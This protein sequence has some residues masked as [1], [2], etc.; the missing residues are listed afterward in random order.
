[1]PDEIR[2]QVRSFFL[3]YAHSPPLPGTPHVAPDQ[4]VRTFF[5]DLTN[6]VRQLGSARAGV[7]PGFFDQEIP[8]GSDRRASL[9]HALST[10]EVFVPLYS[11]GYFARSRPGREWACFE[12][13]LTDAGV[14]NPIDRIAPVLWIPL[15]PG[16]DP[17]GLDQALAIGAGESAYAENGLR[18]LLRLAP[19][20]ESY[21]RI[22][23]Q[24]AGQIVELAENAPVGPSAVRDIDKVASPFGQSATA[25]FTITVAAPTQSGLPVGC[26]PAAYGASRSAWRPF[27][28]VQE[29]SLAEYVAT[30][31]EQLDFA[32]ALADIDQAGSELAANPGVILIDPWFA[33][34]EI[35]LDALRR[36][37]YERPWILP[38]LVPT[39][40]DDSGHEAML[41]QRIRAAL[42]E[43]QPARTE[44]ARQAVAG[45][46]SFERF[47][48]LVPYV[49]AEASRQYLRHGPGNRQTELPGPQLQI[50]G[51][52]LTSPATHE[53]NPDDPAPVQT[54]PQSRGG[55][56]VTFYSF[57]GG[58]G[59]TMAL[60]N[61]AWILAANG[62][63]VLV[64]DWD[65]EA[66]G[67]DRF[68]LPF[69][70]EQEV[71]DGPGIIDLIRDY[72]R[73]AL[74]TDPANREGLISEFSRVQRYAFSLNWEFPDYGCL[75]FLSA[76]KQNRDYVATLSALDWDS[77]YESLNGGEFL[78]ALRADMKR[79]YD[80]VLI[81]SR[82][83]LSDIAD[84]CTLHLPD[85]LVDCF[86][87][88]TQG[89]EGAA[90]IA[91]DIK[92][93]HSD[94]GIRVLP[95]TM[96]VDQAEKE[97]VDAGRLVAMRQFSGLPEGMTDVQRREYWAA[98]EIP[99]QA[100]YAYEETLAVFG[101]EPGKP[102]SLLASFERLTAQITED[103]VTSLPPMDEQLR[104]RN[105]VKFTRSVPLV[106]DLIVIQSLAE[107]ALWTEW[108][109]AVSR[110]AGI[111][112][113]QQRLDGEDAEPTATGSDRLRFPRTLTVVSAAYLARRKRLSLPQDR[114]DLAVYVT[115]SP[116]LSEFSSVPAAFL[117]G[118][119][120]SEAIDR[121]RTLLGLIGRSAASSAAVGMRYPGSEP[122]IFEVPA[123][124]AW[125]TGREADLGR[126][127]A[128]LLEYG[129]GGV[130]SVAL[131]GLGGIG[132]TQLALEYAHRFKTN[133]DAIW[134]L[135]CGQPAFIEPSLADLAQRLRESWGLNVVPSAN[136]TETARQVLDLLSRGGPRW[137]LVFDDADQIEA[138]LPLLPSGGGHVLVTSTNR[139]W[140]E[141]G[142]S[143]LQVDVFTREESVAHLRQ[144]V[145]SMTTDEAEQ[146]AAALGDLP[147]AVATAG[148]WVAETGYTV[149]DFLAEL[150]RQ[151]RRALSVATLPD[152]PE[153]ISKA[154]DVS[155]SR[156][157][158]RSPAA[159]RLFELC[160]IMAPTISLNLIYSPRMAAVLEPF[161]PALSETM[162]IARVVQ[163]IYRLALIKLEPGAGQLIVHTL[164]QEV[165]RDR[166]S[167]E[168]LAAARCDVH[169][170]LVAARPRRDVDDPAT[171]SRYRVIW[172][173]LTVSQAMASAEEGVRHLY[174]D[175]V[176]Y[177]W[178]RG[179]LERGRQLAVEV[180]ACWT[181]MEK[182]AA[183]TPVVAETLRKQLLQL[184]FNL[185]NI[186][187]D[188]GCFAEARELNATIWDEQMRL[189]GDDHPHTLMTAGALAA[190]LRAGGRYREALEMDEKTHQAW[191]ELFGGDHPRTL[192]AA[193][194]LGVSLR[195]TGDFA[196][197]MR[198][199]ADTWERRRATLGPKDPWT[200]NSACSIARDLLEAGEYAEAAVQIEEVCRTFAEVL[201]A[202]S[203][204][205]L[206]SQVLLGIALRSTGRPDEAEELFR[207]ALGELTKKFG[208]SSGGAL[209]CRLSYAVNS[210]S[211]DR[212]AGAA[213]DIRQIFAA[214][215]Q[216]LGSEHPHTLACQVNLAIALRFAGEHQEAVQA[217]RQS[218]D[219]LAAVLGDEHPYALAAKM[220][221]GV[222]LADA[223]DLQE[224]EKAEA[225]AADG[226]AR[227]L[228]PGHPDTLRCRAN[229]LLTR[230]QR[231]DHAAVAQRSTVVDQLAV[232]LGGD[233]PT[234]T[235]HAAKT[236]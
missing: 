234:V 60:A 28:A 13:R 142:V 39:P 160:S 105:M 41:V 206:E 143:P 73:A 210:L 137:L 48:A 145:P 211:L 88:S 208:G 27:P 11:P 18:A 35:G 214:Y 104:K 152:H 171:W 33:A 140:A 156:L 12:R 228:G 68:F 2:P 225:N 136:P 147:L 82:T 106:G 173:H 101:D 168:E 36:A 181:A 84:I 6:S 115:P 166:M 108:I 16:H 182:T 65:L 165:V 123:R 47:V 51:G 80:Y 126:L 78:D 174:I 107:D 200:L 113:R 79:N 49:I 170:V 111:D 204:E 1:V 96:R 150:E 55:R 119:P 167:P 190:D 24:L 45:V 75:D 52:E 59:R 195:V 95:V 66:P 163:E 221:A 69:L 235:T 233:H 201:G 146:I 21:W 61:V 212:F 43:S 151:P 22:V 203:K 98:I 37:V 77:F 4:W 86:T 172:P 20:R 91:R 15:R 26:D 90:R 58:T 198:L 216:R 133:Y 144:R 120:E 131:Q 122:Q 205:V 155:L 227:V 110:D 220:S 25:V 125:F 62:H 7:A 130:P 213:A 3:S 116:S 215:E 19:Y 232:L 186:L 236:G 71:Q 196:A 103:A 117:Y 226:M 202:D 159:A 169:D 29:L 162:V 99:Y 188:L 197:A 128:H 76:G 34:D 64:A 53:D 231:G 54:S 46:D 164:V 92:L 93:R 134:W 32:A 230:Q 179:D 191:T 175:R 38:I 149:S 112:V 153:P 5:R 57:K 229:L 187:R 132:K 183:A 184:R 85:V 8:L 31:A 154:W 17:I 224:A 222:L 14:A 9:A 72:E 180:D 124:N 87:L 148:A 141:S 157:R 121:L 109:I 185:G 89:I 94:R 74:K 67:L 44:T 81:D 194:N 207:W 219:G 217:I 199:N 118:V 139:A 223:G 178:L 10:A 83:G 50:P 209:A 23:Q 102:G 40:D 193:N 100:F 138:I 161:D 70:G 56:I 30:L 114:P 135:N 129:T 63:R 192:F 177:L 158:E 218:I 176:R 42:D 97:K 127:R 189:L